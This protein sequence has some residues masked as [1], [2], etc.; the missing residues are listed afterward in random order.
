MAQPHELRA[1]DYVNRPY[2]MVSEAVRS[3]PRELFA[4]ATK[5]AISRADKLASSLRVE[6]A[7]LEVGR[8][9]TIDVTGVE[10]RDEPGKGHTTR[11]KLAWRAALAPAIFPSMEADLDIY[12]LS[13]EETQL[14]L[15]GLYRP[16]LGLIGAAMDT[17]VGHRVAEASARRFVEDVA[18]F[19]REDLPAM[20]PRRS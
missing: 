20:T 11:I 7:G 3:G 19:L 4:R 2:A 12:A 8:D 9:V 16:P 17:L 15:H 6:L 1:Y 13:A 5:G 18:K 10:D 14:D